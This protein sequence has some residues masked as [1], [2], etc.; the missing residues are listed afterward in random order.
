MTA[1]AQVDIRPR[2]RFTALNQFYVSCLWL[3]YN[4]QWGALLGIVLP[5]Q[6]AAI[7]GPDQKEKYLGL[8]L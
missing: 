7:V 2:R 1:E 5:D 3:A 4:V 8:V 6:V